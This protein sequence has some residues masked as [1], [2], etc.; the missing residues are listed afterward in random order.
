MRARPS[1][2]PVTSEPL[3]KDPHATN[4]RAVRRALR[5]VA[6]NAAAVVVVAQIAPGLIVFQSG[7]LIKADEINHNFAW[8]DGRIDAIDAAIANIEL[9]EGPQGPAGADT[10]LTDF[11]GGGGQT[12]FALPDLRH[13]APRS[14]NGPP[15]AKIISV[16]GIFPSRF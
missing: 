11:F 14:A 13:V 10:D 5:A 8:L 4:P 6:A 9:T 12:T 7:D 1:A 15:L 2:P 16:E 3:G